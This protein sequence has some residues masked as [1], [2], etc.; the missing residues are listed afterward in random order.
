M[1]EQV[2]NAGKGAGFIANPIV[3][4]LPQPLS[5]PSDKHRYIPSSP[6]RLS[7]PPPTV[8]TTFPRH[9]NPILHFTNHPPFQAPSDNKTVTEGPG[10][11][12]SD[13]LA[14][15]SLKSGGS[16]AGGDAAASSQPAKSTTTNTTD[17][18]G[19]TVMA[20]AQ[21]AAV[22][23]DGASL[24]SGSG[25]GYTSTSTSS[26]SGSTGSV[27]V[28]GDP[29]SLGGGSSHTSSYASAASDNTAENLKPKGANITEGGFD[30]SAPNASWTTEIGT[31]KDPGRV[32]ERQMEAGN[33]RAGFDAGYEG[34]NDKGIEK[35]QNSFGE[36]GGDTS[37]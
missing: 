2:N 31:K 26:G 17:T 11:I 8:L 33:S 25:A 28:K 3:R 35:G 12:L 34:A 32:A 9:L 36:L 20:P 7:S 4:L 10:E 6:P 5:S 14:A 16:F 21:S 29:I 18:S 19:A 23:D 15:D 37:A 30:S 13:S 1:S 22:R 24:G 27:N